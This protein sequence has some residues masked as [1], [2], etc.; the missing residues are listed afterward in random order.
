MLAR[1]Y[2]GEKAGYC[3]NYVLEKPKHDKNLSYHMICNI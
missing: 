2:A 3:H 1:E